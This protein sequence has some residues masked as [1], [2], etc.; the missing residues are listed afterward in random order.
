MIAVGLGACARSQVTDRANSQ[1]A[2][3]FEDG[4]E[5][6]F[7]AKC[8]LCHGTEAPA[9][10]LRLDSWEAVFEGGDH[11]EAVIP[12]DARNSLLVE[13]AT[14]LRGGPHPAELGADTLTGGEL[15]AIRAWIDGGAKNVDGEVPFS[16]S[17]NL[18][19]AC[20]Q[21][22]ASVSV[23]DMDVKV[24]IRRVDLRNLGFS[25]TSRPHHVAVEPGGE[26]WYVS[27]IGADAVL[28][29]NRRNEL[30]GRAEFERPGMLV[31]DPKQDILLVGRSMKAVNPPQRIGRIDRSTMSVEEL[32][33]FIARPHALALSK[34]NRFLYTAS[35]A[36]NQIVTMNRE[37]EQVDLYNVPGP[38]HTLVQFAVA[39]DGST[40]AVGGQLTGKLL[41]FDLAHP[42]APELADS[43]DVAAGPWHPVYS[44]DGRFIYFGNKGANKVTIVNARARALAA[45]ISGRGI[46]QPHGS[47]ISADGRWLFI[48]NNNLDGSYI[49]RYNLGDNA[50]VGTVVVIDT[51]SRR[52]VKVIEAGL[53]TTG[54]G[55]V[56]GL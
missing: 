14:E 7:E 47:A 25:A 8:T 9:E 48:S 33:V 37:T 31:A 1:P 41:F 34:D 35:L 30:V 29:F 42:D 4:I 39:P 49:P 52:I 38:I 11:G 16:E 19:Y 21:G 56:T 50:N 53:N 36:A 10:G 24:V 12:F 18:L 45:E 54:L 26:H 22:E 43:V 15:A 51:A 46:A 6:V 3:T 44:P 32:D 55:A 2:I 40:L 23:I 28:K 5:Q 17:T 20:N 13:L 27:L